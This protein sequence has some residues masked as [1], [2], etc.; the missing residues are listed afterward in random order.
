M[1]KKIFHLLCNKYTGGLIAA[2]FG[3]KIPNCRYGFK[4]FNTAKGYC[5]NTV[6]AMIFW[7]FYESAEMRLI[8]KYIQQD[9][10]VVE[11]GASLGIVSSVAISSVDNATSYT[12][13]EA[14]PYLIDCI[15]SNLKKFHT[16]RKNISIENK[17]IAYT[18]EDEVEIMITKNNTQ[19]RISYTTGAS[20]EGVK[21]KATT[22]Q[23]YSTVPYILICDI[24]GM[25]IEIIKHDKDSLQNCRQL[26]IELHKAWYLS[27]MF[28][29]NELESFITGMGFNLVERDGNVFYFNKP[30]YN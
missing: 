13:I 30:A 17:A 29:V 25:E 19:G 24:E 2:L 11:L 1:K 26:F 16:G 10:P 28:E 5:N 23:P 3:N 20:T 8:P 15:N 4:R 18:P 22:L 9:L 27:D 6:K 21:V 7:G 14:N 12:C